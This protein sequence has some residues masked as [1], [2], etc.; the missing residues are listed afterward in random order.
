[1]PLDPEAFSD[2]VIETVER[3]VDRAVAPYV[4]RIVALE[5]KSTAPPIVDDLTP[6]DMAASLSGLLRKE[7]ELPA[8]IR[9]RIEKVGT[10]YVVTEEVVS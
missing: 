7:L 6:E 3:A 4:E 10:G 5:A 8:S 1:M 9:K 2:L